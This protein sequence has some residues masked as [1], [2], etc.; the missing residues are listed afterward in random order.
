MILI[1]K[2]IEFLNIAI[3]KQRL[4]CLSSMSDIQKINKYIQEIETKYFGSIIYYSLLYPKPY[5]LTEQIA[6]L[7]YF[8]D[9]F[10]CFKIFEMYFGN[11]NST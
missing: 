6:W 5:L 1:N 4:M 7:A 11:Q 2:S 9:M 10:F 8:L 3:D